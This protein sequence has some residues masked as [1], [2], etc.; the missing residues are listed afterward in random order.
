MASFILTLQAE[1]DF[2]DIGAYTQETWGHNQAI[3]YLTKLD[4]TFRVLAAMPD[5]G[6]NRDDLRPNLKSYPCNRHMIF[7]RRNGQGDVEILRILHQ[8]MDF[9]RHL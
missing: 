2:N 3:H 4:E 6:K 1:A 7:F 8:R 9:E 5:L